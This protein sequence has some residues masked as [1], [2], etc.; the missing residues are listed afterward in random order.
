MH[1]T[2]KECDSMT[3]DHSPALR[4]YLEALNLLTHPRPPFAASGKSPQMHN[5]Q[6]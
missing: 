1:T 2:T 4:D 6:F 3:S 5:F